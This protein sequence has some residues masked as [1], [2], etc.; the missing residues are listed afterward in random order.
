MVRQYA[1]E[2]IATE[3]ERSQCAVGDEEA[4][5]KETSALTRVKSPTRKAD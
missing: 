5:V 4:A 2:R 3:V 1:E